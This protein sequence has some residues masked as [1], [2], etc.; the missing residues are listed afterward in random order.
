MSEFLTKEELIQTIRKIER[1][2]FVIGILI[3]MPLGGIVI[4]IV[5]SLSR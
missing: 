4:S 1:E 2:A 5:Q 3:G